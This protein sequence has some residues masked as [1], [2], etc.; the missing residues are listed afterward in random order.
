MAGGVGEAEGAGGCGRS[1]GL[2]WVPGL[3]RSWVYW[4]TG[5]LLLTA[6]TG[7]RK[8]TTEV[9]AVPPVFMH[10]SRLQFV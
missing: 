9:R 6:P 7:K 5:P 4:T 3:V 1:M 10:T 2:N 8:L